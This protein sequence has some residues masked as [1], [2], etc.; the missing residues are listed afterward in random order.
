[1]SRLASCLVAA[2]CLLAVPLF[3]ALDLLAHLRHKRPL[4]TPFH[5]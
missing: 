1:M 3:L 5:L 4:K 2:A